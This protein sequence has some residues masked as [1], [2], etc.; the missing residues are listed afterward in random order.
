[1]GI[2]VTAVYVQGFRKALVELGLYEAVTAKLPARTVEV[3]NN[4]FS[5]RTHPLEI[6]RDLVDTTFEVAGV[7]RYQRHAYVMAR[8]S[9]GKILTPMFKV[10]LALTGRTPATLMS[11]VPQSVSQALRGVD[12]QWVPEGP[13]GGTL[14]IQY[15]ISVPASAEFAWRGT[16]QFLFELLEGTPTTI[17]K[18]TQEDEN[19]RL[20]I[21]VKW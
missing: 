11:R 4:P 12:A 13:Q 5:A 6:F 7:E 19:R 10:A 15:P 1:M 14:R 18:V 9:L 21:V 20:L 16:L 2:E 17:T 8:E 3:L